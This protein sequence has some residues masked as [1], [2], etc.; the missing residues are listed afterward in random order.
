M[1]ETTEAAS[2]GGESE[3]LLAALCLKELLNPTN[4]L[5]LNYLFMWMKG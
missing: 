1:D 5:L 4:I 3:L 2:A